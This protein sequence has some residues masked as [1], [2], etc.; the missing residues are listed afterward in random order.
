MNIQT[1]SALFYKIL[2]LFILAQGLGVFLA[3]KISPIIALESTRNLSDFSFGQFLFLAAFLI[4]FSILI[5][6]MPRFSSILLK[7]FLILIVFLMTQM[8]LSLWLNTFNSTLM[9]LAL[10]IVFLIY[11]SVFIHD[12]LM[13]IAF[14]GVGAVVG[15][16]LQPLAVVY[17]LIIFSFYDI[18][19]VYKTGQMVKLADAMI[20]SRAIFGFIIPQKFG[21]FFSN[22]RTAEPGEDFMILGSGDVILPL[23]LSASIAGQSIPK[24]LIIAACSVLGVLATSILFMSQKNKPLTQGAKVARRPMAALPPIAALTIIGYLI[25]R[26]F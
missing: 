2:V 11:R 9:A 14:A 8:V 3:S 10:T 19:A 26:F 16:T 4:I 7:L 24:A 17:L 23:L 18:V 22:L 21:G 20:R 5:A 1:K 12:L 6:R 25:T 15:V 13:I